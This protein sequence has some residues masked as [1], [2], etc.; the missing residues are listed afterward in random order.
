MI[1]PI[2]AYYYQN[3]RTTPLGVHLPFFERDSDAEFFSSMTFQS[4]IS[5]YTVLG[6]YL[7]QIVTCS[8]I[9][10]IAMFPDMIGFN[11]SEL[12]EEYKANK[13]CLKSIVRLRNAMIQIRD[14]HEYIFRFPL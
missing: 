1:G 3:A 10:T 14:F 9:S 4:G 5:V 11:L 8:V 6:N 7:E 2:Y 13:V 12:Y